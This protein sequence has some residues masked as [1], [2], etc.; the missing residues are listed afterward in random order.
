[1]TASPRRS[2]ASLTPV[3]TPRPIARPPALE[4]VPD[5][6]RGLP[7]WVVW[8]FIHDGQRWTKVPFDPRTGH[9]AS[10]ADPATWALFGDAVTAYRHGGY[11]GI[12]LQLTRP[13]IG[14]DLEH[15]IV[16]ISVVLD[17]DD[18]PDARMKVSEW[19]KQFSGMNK[20]ES[21]AVDTVAGATKTSKWMRHGIADTLHRFQAFQ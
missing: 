20:A 10:C 1:M 16:G 2:A 8:R 11:D 4:A 13:F 17:P 21:E 5:A 6:L 3:M 19:I 18:S 15:R 9:P 7:A 14:V 12:G